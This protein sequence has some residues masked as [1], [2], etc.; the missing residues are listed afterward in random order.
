[1]IAG[2]PAVTSALFK[3]VAGLWPWASGVIELP[4][5]QSLAF[6]PQRPFLPHGTL[7]ALLSYPAADSAFTDAQ[8]HFALE[9]AGVAWLAPRL[10][11][12]DVWDRMLPLRTQQRLAF[13]RLLLQK[14]CWIFIEEATDA[15]DIEG[16]QDLMEMLQREL[17][18]ACIITISFHP[19]LERLHQ[20]KMV[21]NRLCE[22]KY[23]FRSETN[24]EKNGL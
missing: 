16:E 17:S 13:A 4:R 6:L 20:R 14:P 7:R 11:D 12:S 18:N 23:L 22:E 2:D 15:L 19:G 9:C 21:L 24:K 8:L 10:D 3:A 1:L 5:Q